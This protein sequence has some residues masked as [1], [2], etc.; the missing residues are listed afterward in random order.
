M[1]IA[2]G[3]EPWAL[4]LVS[5]PLGSD[6]F[7]ASFLDAILGH[8]YHMYIWAALFCLDLIHHACCRNA[9]VELAFWGT[10]Y[11]KLGNDSFL[12]RGP[13]CVLVFLPSYCV[14]I[15]PVAK[16]VCHLQVSTYSG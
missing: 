16:Q 3:G 6:A 12:S 14:Q 1:N 5:G 11:Y 2:L 7:Y 13:F 8:I 10:V 15:W 4:V 9:H